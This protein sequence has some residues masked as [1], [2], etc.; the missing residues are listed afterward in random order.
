MIKLVSYRFIEGFA[1]NPIV[2]YSDQNVTPGLPTFRLL[3][4][5]LIFFNYRPFQ[6]FQVDSPYP[7]N[8]EVGNA[9]FVTQVLYGLIRT[10]AELFGRFFEKRV[11]SELL[12]WRKR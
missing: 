3:R 11:L 7:S 10:T 8:S 4:S 12:V 6:T 2:Y 9:E 5:I 1:V